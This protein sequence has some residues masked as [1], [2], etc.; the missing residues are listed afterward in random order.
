MLV[1]GCALSLDF[2]FNLDLKPRLENKTENRKGNPALGPHPHWPAH[3][4]PENP[5]RAAQLLLR[6]IATAPWDPLG[7]LTSHANMRSTITWARYI[8]LLLPN[9]HLS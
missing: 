2:K 9:L 8:N 4:L 3:L 6:R 1:F 7:G 5:H